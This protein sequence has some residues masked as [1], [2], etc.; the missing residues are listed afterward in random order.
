MNSLFSKTALHHS[1]KMITGITRICQTT[2]F[3]KHNKWTE[4]KVRAFKARKD[5]KI[6]LQLLFGHMAARE[7]EFS[8]KEVMLGNDS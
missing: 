5:D 1:T 8:T 2:E 7:A 4:N 6:T 3:P